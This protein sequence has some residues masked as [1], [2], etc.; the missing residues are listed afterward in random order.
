VEYAERGVMQEKL[1]AGDA[2]ALTARTARPDM[3]KRRTATRSPGAST[4]T[5][6]PQRPPAGSKRRFARSNG[7]ALRDAGKRLRVLGVDRQEVVHWGFRTLLTSEDWVERYIAA[8]TSAEALDMARRYEPH[9]ALVDIALG[10]ES[11]AELCTNLRKESPITHVL[12]LVSGSRGMSVQAARDVGAFGIVPK[13]WSI[14]D[15]AGAARMVGLGMTLFAPGA[16]TRPAL[17]SERELQVLDLVAAGSTNREI[18]DR[19]Y[20]S[21]HT[22]KDHTSALYRKI[23]ARNRAEAILRAQRLGLLS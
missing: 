3:A 20:L 4:A 19:L 11:G 21:P 12:L 5:A 1:Q 7:Q 23:G 15:I 16:R 6:A 17:L 22:V 9:V 18:A 14:H 2:A 13:E 10:A 8:A